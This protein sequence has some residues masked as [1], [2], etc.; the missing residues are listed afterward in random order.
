MKEFAFTKDQA[1][2]ISNL[3]NWYKDENKEKK[4]FI[5]QGYAGT[6]K[7]TIIEKAIE[8]LGLTKKEVS[9]ASYTGS[10]VFNMM[11]KGVNALTIHKLIYNT[12]AFEYAVFDDGTTSDEFENSFS[13]DQGEGDYVNNIYVPKGKTLVDIKTKMVTSLK[14]ELDNPETKIVIIDEYSM[15][16]DTII[17]DI[18]SFDSIVIIFIGDPGQLPPIQGE[19]R[20]YDVKDAFLEK[21]MR[22]ENGNL[23]IDASFMARIMKAIP[24]GIYGKNLIVQPKEKIL[25]DIN[26]FYDKVDQIIVALNKT[27]KLINQEI[28]RYKRYEGMFPKQ[29]EKIICTLNN[30]DFTAYSPKLNSFI[31]LVNGTIGRVLEV[32][33]IDMKNKKFIIDFQLEFDKDCI[34]ENVII[35]F[36]NFDENQKYFPGNLNKDKDGKFKINQFDFGYAITCHKAQGSQYKK[37]LIIAEKISYF[38]GNTIKDDARWLYTA[39]TR[40][41]DKV[42]LA[43]DEDYYNNVNYEKTE[44]YYQALHEC[45]KDSYYE[46]DDY[47]DGIPR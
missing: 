3:I 19:N 29:G 39:I 33:N 42:I 40:G 47:D 43:Y 20:L 45:R 1:D 44:D 31:P 38:K 21:I 8:K 5:L 15:I 46:E 26:Y 12:Q 18:L 30:W 23:I 9:L 10:S 25:D 7:T 4:Y 24:Y 17:D 13:F 27:R 34:F 22:Q 41:I 36:Y 37:V 16:N 6:G 14:N 28:R 2:A 35:S 32:K 11:Q